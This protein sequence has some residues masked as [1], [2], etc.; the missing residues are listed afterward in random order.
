MVRRALAS[1]LFFALLAGVH[2]PASAQQVLVDDPTSV[3]PGAAQLEAWH[4]REESWIAPA[5]RVHPRLE[6]AAGTAFLRGAQANQRTVEYSLEGKVLLRPGSVH[7]I[8]AAVV[9]GIGAQELGLPRGRPASTYAYGILSQTLVPDRLTAY[10]N[11]G[12]RHTDGGPHELTWG[13]RLDGSLF[14][15]FILIGEAYG[16]GHTTSLQAALRTVLLTNRIEADVSI[17]RSAIGATPKTWGTVG[18][19]FMSASLY[20]Q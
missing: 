12:W 3:A 8:G 7:R 19:T 9:S 5:F 4:S 13:V 20:S 1:V 2:F 16:E 18:F 6:L 15:R 11:L 14:D 17:T 10:Q